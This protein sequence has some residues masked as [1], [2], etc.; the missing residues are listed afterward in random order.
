MA[1]GLEMTCSL[2]YE[3]ECRQDWSLEFQAQDVCDVSGTYGARIQAIYAEEAPQYV[4]MDMT[5]ALDTA[6]VKVLDSIPSKGNGYMYKDSEVYNIYPTKIEADPNPEC[7]STDESII[8]L[9]SECNIH[10]V[11]EV[12]NTD[13]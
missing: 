12:D 4:Q 2:D 11:S 1:D 9:D 5:M 6:C 7:R 13:G 10:F 8:T 3:A